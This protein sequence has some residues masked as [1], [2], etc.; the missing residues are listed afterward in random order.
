MHA[1][2]HDLW[3]AP[4]AS[5]EG[6]VVLQKLA[7]NGGDGAGLCGGADGLQVA[8]GAK[9]PAFA[10]QHQYPDALVRFDISH[11]L[12]KSLD[13]SEI[14]RVKGCWS[15]EQERNEQTVGRKQRRLAC[16]DGIGH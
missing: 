4:Q 14:D 3:Y 13:D 8:A 12:F 16:R 7:D 6:V 15:V 10:L 9:G 1:G 5:D 2:E 11:E